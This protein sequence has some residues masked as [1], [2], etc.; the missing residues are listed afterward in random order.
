MIISALAQVDLSI[1]ARGQQQTSVPVFFRFRLENYK[2]CFLWEC[3]P[4]AIPMKNKKKFWLNSYFIFFFYKFMPPDPD[5]GSAL[6]MRIRI[7]RPK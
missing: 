1:L 6:G 4:V 2:F 7:L 3:I 5:P